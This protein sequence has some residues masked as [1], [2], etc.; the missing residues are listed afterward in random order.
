MQTT[1]TSIHLAR[2]LTVT[3][4]PFS[5]MTQAGMKKREIIQKQSEIIDDLRASLY[6][7][8]ERYKKLASF[9]G[10]VSKPFEVLATDYSVD[11]LIHRIRD[12]ADRV[13]S[14]T[15][16]AVGTAS[17]MD[18]PIALNQ[19]NRLLKRLCSAAEVLGV[20][21]KGVNVTYDECVG[22]ID[23]LLNKATT[24]AG[25][26]HSPAPNI[27]MDLIKAI[28][29]EAEALHLKGIDYL[30]SHNEQ[31]Q[32]IKT[33]SKNAQ[34]YAASTLTQSDKP[35]EESNLLSK[36]SIK[37]ATYAD[38]LNIF[39]CS[40]PCED[41]LLSFID[42][43]ADMAKLSM[44]SK[45]PSSGNGKIRNSLLELLQTERTGKLKAIALVAISVEDNGVTGT[46]RLL[47]CPDNVLMHILG[48]TAMQHKD[49]AEA[50]A[51][52][53]LKEIKHVDKSDT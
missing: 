26:L 20:K 45:T 12:I 47:H 27:H 15:D 52:V 40:I 48:S 50:I 13:N 29:A 19:R 37:I 41:D 34:A 4:M 10:E 35:E 51:R 18:G 22:Y 2:Y 8:Y 6:A 46:C 11:D 49:I 39:G 3:P 44:Q 36:M 53:E 9:I 38:E 14:A 33:M 30:S 42:R 32:Y 23:I 24:V 5:D 21:E 17:K 25:R 7:E 28:N 1:D 16:D 31:L 43:I